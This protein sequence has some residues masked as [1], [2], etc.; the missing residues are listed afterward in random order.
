M[1]PLIVVCCMLQS[2]WVA[3]AWAESTSPASLLTATTITLDDCLAAALAGQPKIL[4]V[5]SDEASAQGVLHQATSAVLPQLTLSSNYS[6]ASNA[7]NVGTA[8]GHSLSGAATVKQLLWDFGRSFHLL[9]EARLNVQ[10]AAQQTEATRREVV[11]SVKTAYY[12]AEQAQEN[13]TVAAEAVRQAERHLEQT[14]GFAEVGLRSRVDVAA[15]EAALAEAKANLVQAT[16]SLQLAKVQLNEATGMSRDTEYTLA[17]SPD[18]EAADLPLV[19]L[20]AEALR[21]RAELQRLTTLTQGAGE[22]VAARRA[23]RWPTL[24]ATTAVTERKLESADW[25]DNWNIGLAASWPIWDSGNVTAQVQ[26]AQ[27]QVERL[28]A[29]TQE[30][31]LEATE[32]AVTAD[33]ERLRLVE[34]QFETGLTSTIDTIDAQQQLL[35]SRT[36]RVGARLNWLIAAAELEQAVGR[37]LEDQYATRD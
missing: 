24:S 35:A 25:S 14:R 20:L 32:A 27:A 17:A 30:T 29:Q 19:E 12:L 10:G 8:E 21:T 33:E 31:T 7:G 13:I 5:R 18:S 1:K 26:Q 6:F 16:N 15:S 28:K 9:T 4:V 2:W 36:A 37:P 3:C 11:L 22:E 23:S 34:G